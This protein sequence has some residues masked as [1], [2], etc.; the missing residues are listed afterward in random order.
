MTVSNAESIPRVG[1]EAYEAFADGRLWQ[2]ARKLHAFLVSLAVGQVLLVVFDPD[3]FDSIQFGVVSLILLGYSFGLYWHHRATRRVR[4][5]PVL[6]IDGSGIAVRAPEAAS[7]R[8][9]R[10]RDIDGIAWRGIDEVGVR[11]Q[12]RPDDHIAEVVSIPTGLLPEEAA[13]RVVDAIEAHVV[14]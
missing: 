5:Q 9:L 11:L 1:L 2:R 13:G 10:W 8:H 3:G 6:R 14:E 4:E 12:P 7:M